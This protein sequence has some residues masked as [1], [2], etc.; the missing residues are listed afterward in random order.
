[1]LISRRALAG[2]SPGL[3][4]Y[5]ART[6]ASALRLIEP[7]TF[8]MRSSINELTALRSNRTDRQTSWQAV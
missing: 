4:G 3:S 6:G 5:Q 8:K 1:M 2:A 7:S